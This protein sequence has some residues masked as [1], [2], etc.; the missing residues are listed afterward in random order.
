MRVAILVE[1][2]SDTAVREL[3]TS[4]LKTRI[5]GRMPK[6]VYFPQGGRIPKGTALRRIVSQQLGHFDFVV[7]ITDVYTGQREFHSADDAKSQMRSWVGNEPRFFPHAAQYEFEAWLIPYWASV[8][9]IA[10][11]TRAA[12]SSKPE[13]INHGRPP[14]K[15][16][17]QVFRSG[18]LKRGY[19]KTRDAAAILRD[20]DLSIAIEAC[21]E[22]KALVNTLLGIVGEPEI[23]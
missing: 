10:R 23:P 16:L 5:R 20:Q 1:G 22:L 17:E 4:F 9:R 19:S 3:L 13:T 18:P 6:I 12:P 14:S 8:C 2:P 21:P 11:T 15:C 7:A